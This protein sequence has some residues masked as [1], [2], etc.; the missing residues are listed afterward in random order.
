MRNATLAFLIVLV[1][2]V[3]GWGARTSQPTQFDSNQPIRITS[4]R[5]SAD[6]TAR[7][8]TFLGHV[9]AR[10]G[11]VTIYADDLT[12]FYQ[13]G[14]RE[15]ERVEAEGDVRVVQNNRVATGQKGIYYRQQGRIVLT[16]S[17]AIHQGENSIKGDAITVFLNEEKSIVTGDENTRVNAVFQPKKGT[18]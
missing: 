10:K 16:G 17:P 6:D 1:A 5:L 2:A 7:Q 8:M 4:D 11:D 13:Q 14:S 9:V 15:V 18:P 3:S 12:V